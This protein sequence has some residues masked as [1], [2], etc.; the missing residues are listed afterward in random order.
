VGKLSK[1]YALQELGLAFLTI[2]GTRKKKVQHL[3]LVEPSNFL[4]PP[5]YIT[6]GLM[7]NFVKAVDQTGPEFRYLTAKLP[8]ISAA[9]IVSRQICKLFRD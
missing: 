5:L 1:D 7:K 4:L 2:T 3:L 8:G 6:L 9:K